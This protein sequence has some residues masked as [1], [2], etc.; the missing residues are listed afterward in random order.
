MASPCGMWDSSSWPGIETVS[1]AM[2][3]QSL[4]YRTTSDIPSLLLSFK[5][6]FHL[7]KYVF[8]YVSDYNTLKFYFANSV[9]WII[10][11]INFHFFF[12]PGWLIFSLSLDLV[13]SDY[14]LDIVLFC[15]DTRFSYTNSEC[16][17][18]YFCVGT[19]QMT[20]WDWQQTLSLGQQLRSHL[21]SLILSQDA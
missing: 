2:E 9:I 16:W 12:S 21:S 8:L 17:F 15:V 1:P 20:W 4:N 10:S 5:K 6:S 13:I 3:T 14:V 7:L 18:Y 11:R 19:Q